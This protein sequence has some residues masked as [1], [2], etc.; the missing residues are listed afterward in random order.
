[1][2][3][4]TTQLVAL[5]DDAIEALLTGAEEYQIR[6][7]KVKRTDLESLMRERRILLDEQ[8]RSSS[9]GSIFRLGAF[10]RVR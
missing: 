10:S 2:A 8:N 7:R 9:A 3:L 4:S 5:I 6:D 1:M